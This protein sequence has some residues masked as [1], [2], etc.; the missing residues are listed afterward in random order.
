MIIGLAQT[1]IVWENKTCNMKKMQGCLEAFARYIKTCGDGDK[2]ECADGLILFP[3]MSLTGFSM[4]T[5]ITAE[6]GKETVHMCEELA[7]S[8]GL[9]IGIGWVA[10]K[11]N[12]ECCENHYSI[13]TP[14]AGEILDYIKLHPFAYSGEDAF[15]EGGSSLPVCRLRDM[16]LG[17][18]VC[19]DLRFPEVFQIL[20]DKADMIVVPANWPERRNAHWKALLAARAIENQCYI[21]GVNCCG[22]MDGQ[23]YSGDSC[24]YAPDGTCM[25]PVKVIDSRELSEGTYC[26]EQN[27]E[28]AYADEECVLVYD[29]GACADSVRLV[30]KSFPVKSARRPELYRRLL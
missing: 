7:R 2:V 12:A 27:R 23:Y 8:Y 4:H 3:E 19:F 30:R 13:I 17:A 11:E 15:F 6:H 24:M 20:S 21:A 22:L 26:V 10:G 18:A 16:C 29:V 14:D 25:E 28:C 9:S 5:D 1:H